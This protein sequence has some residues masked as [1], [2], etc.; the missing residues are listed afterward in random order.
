[1]VHI[2]IYP[3]VHRALTRGALVFC[4]SPPTTTTSSSSSVA[5]AFQQRT[6]HRSRRT[7]NTVRLLSPT[8]R[9]EVVALVARWWVVEQSLEVCTE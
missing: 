3:Q 9:E 5:A 7:L 4:L 1:M 2:P 6:T 8:V